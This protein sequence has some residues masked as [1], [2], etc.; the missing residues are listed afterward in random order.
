MSRLIR[1]ACVQL[2][3]GQDMARNLDRA[4][5]R[6]REAQAQGARFIALP[7]N[8]PLMEHRAEISRAQAAPTESHPAVR[9]FSALASE[10]GVHILLGSHAALAPNGK[11]SNRSVLF[12]DKGS[13][14]AAYDKVHM[15]DVDIPD[16]ATYRESETFEP[17][18]DA[19]IAETPFA[20]IGLTV[21][22]DVR[23]AYLYRM[24]AQGGAELLTVPAAFTKLTGEAHWHV[25]LRARAI[26]TGCF[27]VAPAQCGSHS[28]NRR[29]F[30]HSL[31]V[32]PWGAVLAD[33]GEAEGV[34]VAELDLDKVAEAR[35]RIPAL[36]HDRP[37]ALKA[38][39]SLGAAAG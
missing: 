23:F 17:G 31:I 37:V 32:D 19:V 8:A 14:V 29:T 22:Y 21:C 36:R 18:R 26:E 20:R 33:G 6:V 13:I 34:I 15:F 27:V 35:G 4:E 1:A 7:E 16:G 39:T 38:K 25:L 11:L 5:A 10:L 24:L 2:N 12:D 3:G 28:G 9:R 30:G